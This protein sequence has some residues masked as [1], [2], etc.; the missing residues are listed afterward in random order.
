MPVL[1]QKNHEKNASFK[2]SKEQKAEGTKD[3]L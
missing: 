3:E 2:L 1:C